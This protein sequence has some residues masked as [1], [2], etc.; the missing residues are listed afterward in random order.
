MKQT[1]ETKKIKDMTEVQLKAE[2]V[3]AKK[4]LA[5][6]ILKVKVGKLDNYSLVKKNKK[7]VARIAT[8]INEK[9]V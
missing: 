4:K 3:S 1:E 6:D 7:Y 2:L 8:I 5:V 9:V